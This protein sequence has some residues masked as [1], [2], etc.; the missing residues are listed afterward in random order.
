MSLTRQK[1]W[2]LNNGVKDSCV[3]H[4]T[5]ESLQ[6]D[7]HGLG[8]V[9]HAC[10]PTTKESKGG[11]S[12]VGG[13]PGMCRGN[14]ISQQKQKQTTTTITTTIITT[15]NRQ[16]ESWSTRSRCPG[17]RKRTDAIKEKCSPCS[18]NLPFGHCWVRPLVARR[19]ILSEVRPWHRAF[20]WARLLTLEFRGRLTSWDGGCLDK[21]C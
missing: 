15:I 6:G 1:Q 11:W 9:Q 3:S 10:D 12:R 7:E 18:F 20:L 17:A 16:E 8:V 2:I 5:V 19:H 13:Q 4:E 14:P 21:Y